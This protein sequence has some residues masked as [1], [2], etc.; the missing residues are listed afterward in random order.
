MSLPWKE[1]HKP[2]P[3][4]YQLSLK[5][6]WG[7]LRRLRQNP[8]A[9]QEYNHI[10]QDQL[11]KGI[12]EPVSEKTPT[13]NR[14]HYLPHHAVVR[15][16]KSTTK[17]RVVYDASAK[18]DGPSLNECLHTGPKFNQH[19]LNILVRSR[20]YRVA[21]TAD[22]EKAFLMISVTDHDRDV[23][24]FLWVNDVTKEPPEVCVLRFTRVVFG[25]S[26]S[27]FLLNA[28]IK[29][30][31]E[32]YLNSHPDLVA[33]LIQ[34]AYVDDIV[35]GA[36]SEDEAFRL[37][38]EA[39]DLLLHGGFNLRKFRTNSRRL[40]QRINDAESSYISRAEETNLSHSDETYVEATLGNFQQ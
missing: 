39:K 18:S 27:P 40:Q 35:T 28:T 3:D 29:Y 24:R 20:Y 1:F 16:D 14:I 12:I 21:L 13:S 37:Y 33:T 22:I 38:S 30:H 9:L 25:V 10:I 4:H 17:V 7:L 6:I 2:L 36:S 31:L 26:S 15:S 23:L 19:I 5:R 11:K 32:Q 34:S 8:S